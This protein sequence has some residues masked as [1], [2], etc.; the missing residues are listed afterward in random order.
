MALGD[1]IEF[2]IRCVFKKIQF[3]EVT[4]YSSCIGLI[5]IYIIRRKF[6]VNSIG[7]DPIL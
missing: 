6:G 1:L 5:F 4:C 2:N 7:I 3:E